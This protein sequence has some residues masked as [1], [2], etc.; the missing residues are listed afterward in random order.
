[1]KRFIFILLFATSGILA[2]PTV[3]WTS[4]LLFKASR[5]GAVAYIFG[6]SSFS[7][8]AELPGDFREKYLDPSAHILTEKVP[9]DLEP[10]LYPEGESLD[11][12]LSPQSYRK[13]RE[14]IR[15]TTGDL[16]LPY[17]RPTLAF[18]NLTMAVE[19]KS[20]MEKNMDEEIELLAQEMG[21]HG[22]LDEEPLDYLPIILPMLTVDELEQYLASFEDSSALFTS[23]YRRLKEEADC[24]ARTDIPCMVKLIDEPSVP[25]SEEEIKIVQDISI[26]QTNR[27]WIPAIERYSANADGRHIFVSVEKDHLLIQGDSILSLLRERGFTVESVY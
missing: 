25:L 9:S 21:K 16:L 19:E 23:V 14:V 26:R 8:L 27:S 22:Y 18:I 6:Y 15:G 1:M 20:A 10:L 4:S 17:V 3:E 12:K 7:N 24:Y 5:D 13:L 11:Q 2:N